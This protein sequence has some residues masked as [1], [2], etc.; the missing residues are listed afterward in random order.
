VITGEFFIINP[1][2]L[3]RGLIQDSQRHEV[4]L[5]RVVVDS[6]NA[7]KCVII[8]GP[9]IVKIAFQHFK[10]FSSYYKPWI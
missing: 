10:D 3:Q 8:Q 5:F 1:L 4:S 7:V 6:T 9:W 2:C